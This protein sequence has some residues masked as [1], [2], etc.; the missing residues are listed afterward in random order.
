[1]SLYIPDDVKDI[2]YKYKHNL[3]MKEICKEIEQNSYHCMNCNTCLM[4]VITPMFLECNECFGR[5]CSDCAAFL[6]YGEIQSKNCLN[7]IAKDAYIEE[8]QRVL[9]R[10][11]ENMEDDRFLTIL[12]DH[13]L[14]DYEIL[15]LVNYMKDLNKDD[16][17]YPQELH[18]DIN[19][20]C[21][22]EW[23]YDDTSSMLPL[24][25]DL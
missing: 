21:T 14:I 20:F 12:S 5:I 23:G 8:I 11:L 16:Y 24:E 3:E 13:N 19:Q 15:V 6:H 25:Y 17:N 7:C 1:M 22:S 4:N 18:D 9:G 10:K 2:M